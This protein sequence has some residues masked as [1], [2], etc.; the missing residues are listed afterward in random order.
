[1]RS[2]AS[3]ATTVAVALGLVL[4][5]PGCGGAASTSSGAAVS[6]SLAA[7]STPTPQP[8]VDPAV[9][10]A[11]YVELAAAYNAALC[12]Q[13]PALNSGDLEQGKAAYGVLA[14]ANRVLADGFRALQLPPELAETKQELVMAIA[15]VERSMT[16][17]ANAESVE[18]FNARLENLQGNQATAGDLSNFMR[19]EL[20]VPSTPGS[21]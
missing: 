17:L 7:A 2:A 18:E 20:G 15:A 9:A 19:G 12:Q 3:W 5:L 6:P 11:A 1:M 16:D 10:G 4:A 21:C 14:A 8:S 13:M